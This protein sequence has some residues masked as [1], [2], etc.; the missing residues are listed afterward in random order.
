[1]IAWF[2]RLIWRHYAREIAVGLKVV[3][4]GILVYTAFMGVILGVALLFYSVF[5]LLNWVK[6]WGWS[7]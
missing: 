6:L 2:L 3:G 5:H 7:L 1:M 4:L